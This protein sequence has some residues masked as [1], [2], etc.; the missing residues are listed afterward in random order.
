MNDV[1][2][3]ISVNPNKQAFPFEIDYEK[4]YFM[5]IMIEVCDRNTEKNDNTTYAML[6]IEIE[7]ENDN[8]PE[9]IGNTLQVM[10][11]VVEESETD[12]FVGSILARDIDG[13]GN[14]EIKY[15]M[16]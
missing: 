4:Y 12:I 2:A 7:D 5:Y 1:P 10:R 8:A 15:S 6:T 13:P 3:E 16:M 11:R 14:N 9:F